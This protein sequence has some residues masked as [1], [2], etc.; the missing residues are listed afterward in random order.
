MRNIKQFS[1]LLVIALALLALTACTP[2]ELSRDGLVVGQS[3]RLSSGETLNQDLTIAGGSAVLEEGSVLNGDVAVM[4]GTLSIN[5][6]VNGDVSAMGGVVTLGTQAVIRGS[7]NTVGANLSK[8]N[9]AVV[10]GKISGEPG[11]IT[12]PDISNPVIDAGKWIANLFWRIFQAFAVAALAVLVSLFAQRPMER[13][14]DT[15]TAQ[16]ILAGGLGLL[17]LAV[18]PVLFV[19]LA[20]TIVLSPVSLLGLLGLGVALVFGWLVIGMVVGERIARMLNQTWSAPLCAGIG[21]LAVALVNALLGSIACIGWILP[22][23]VSVVGVGGVILTRFGTVPYPPVIHEAAV[24]ESVAV[25]PPQEE[26]S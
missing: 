23:L 10:E 21:T 25:E 15:I 8:A 7:V 3:F 5:G 12:L 4:G 14:G 1:I 11:D 26:V 20:V 9:G 22:F 16:P 2:D 24:I 17:T 13:A 19:I 6:E 18:L